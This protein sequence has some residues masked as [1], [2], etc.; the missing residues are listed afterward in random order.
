MPEHS[1]RK[2]IHSRTGDRTQDGS[3]RFGPAP[4][5]Y[6]IVG[7][8]GIRLHVRPGCLRKGQAAGPA[9]TDKSERYIIECGKSCFF[10]AAILDCLPSGSKFDVPLE[11]DFPVDEEDGHVHDSDLRDEELDEYNQSIRE[12]YQASEML[13]MPNQ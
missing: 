7:D 4:A 3:A 9:T 10:A 6:S 5:T 11:F 2:S 8:S 1:W 13:C 12:T